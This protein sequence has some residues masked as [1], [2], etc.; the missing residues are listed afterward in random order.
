MRNHAAN[1][2]KGQEV[3][4]KCLVLIMMLAWRLNLL[5]VLG[6]PVNLPVLAIAM[7]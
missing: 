5:G 7:M 4:L 2:T 6:I 1:Q 3:N